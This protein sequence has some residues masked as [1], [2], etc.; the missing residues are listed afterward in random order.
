MP[1]S[2]VLHWAQLEGCSPC[3]KY[4]CISWMLLMQRLVIWLLLADQH[5]GRQSHLYCLFH[6]SQ[7]A[8]LCFSPLILPYR[9][10]SMVKVHMDV[11]YYSLV[12]WYGS[13]C[14]CFFY[15]NIGSFVAWE[16]DMAW[17]AT[18]AIL[19]KKIGS[20]THRVTQNSV[21]GGGG[22]GSFFSRNCTKSNE[23][24]AVTHWN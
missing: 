14:N 5:E 10:Y 18:S 9:V 22:G 24:L 1:Q 20:R 12:T 3:N 8:F 2:G 19:L 4:P 7:L 6:I 23:L 16:A 15:R 11:G 13:A 21:G 17:H